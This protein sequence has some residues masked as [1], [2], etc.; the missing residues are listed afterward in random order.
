MITQPA[1]T[2]DDTTMRGVH[3]TFVTGVTVVTTTDQD[4]PK[5]LAVNAFTSISLDPPLVMVCVQQS[6]ATH[7]PLLHSTH[8]G[9][10]ILAADQRSTAAV[11]A[12]KGADKF[13]TIAWERAE[14]G[15]PVLTG[16]CAWMEAEVCQRLDFGT[17]TAFI[18][19]VVGAHYSD[20]PALVYRAGEFFDGSDLSAAHRPPLGS[21]Q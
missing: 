2:V 14:H 6:S 19:Q 1:P 20:R 18:A 4:T 8:L 21:E 9:I 16:A 11:F 17:H 15:S 5:G 12:S 3:R 7:D 13:A 10:N